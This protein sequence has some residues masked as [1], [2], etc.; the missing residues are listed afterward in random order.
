MTAF[1]KFLLVIGIGM[2]P[3]SAFLA[4]INVPGSPEAVISWCNT[5][6]GVLMITLASAYLLYEKR[7]KGKV[8]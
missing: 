1:S 2:V 8:D 7:K 6:L 3:I 5:G 4:S